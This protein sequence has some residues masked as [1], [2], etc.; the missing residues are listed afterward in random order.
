MSISPSAP[1]GQVLSRELSEFLLDFLGAQQ[2]FSM[3]PVG[4]PLLDPAIDSLAKR[5]NTLFLERASVSMGVTPTQF[6][7]SGVPTD[8][9]H[10]MLRELAGKLHRKNVKSSFFTTPS[11]SLPRV[12]S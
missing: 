5:L 12:I 7:V 10:T 1:D 4:H 11:N 6:V 2:R 9:D 8:P 3:Y